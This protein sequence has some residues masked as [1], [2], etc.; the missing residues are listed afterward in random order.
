LRVRLP[1]NWKP[2]G[3]QRPAWDFLENGGKRAFMAWHRRAGK[4]EL[5]L[6]RTGVAAFERVGN[7][8]YMLPEAA[9]ARKAIWDAVNPHTGLR[10]LDEAFPLEIRDTT[11]DQEMM[12]RFANGSTF[13]VVGSDNYNSLVGSPPIGIVGSEWALAKPA[14][15]GFLRP[16]LLENGGWAI[17]N[18]TPRGPNHAKTMFDGAVGDPSW[19]TQKLTVDDTDVFTPEQLASER[20]EMIREYGP[21]FGES[22]FQQEYYC[23]WTAAVIGAYYGK[24]MAAAEEDGRITD[25]PYRKERP[26][27]TAWDIG[28]GNSDATGIWFFQLIGDWIHIIDYYEAVGEGVDHYAKV[29]RDK[30][31]AYSKHIGPHDVRNKEWGSG[32]ARIEV[33]RE[34]GV[35]FRIAPQVSII[36]GINAVRML[37]PRF[38]FDRTKCADGIDALRQYKQDYDED[39]S[40]FRDKPRHDWTSHAADGIRMMALGV[41]DEKGDVPSPLRNPTMDE[42]V[43]RHLQARAAMRS[44]DD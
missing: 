34:L 32:R 44:D 43:S 25:V 10:R 41:K 29:L 5:A 16:I 22:L 14:A 21:Q 11:R 37:F 12:I 15:W 38:R 13:Q 4:D 8:W 27:Q 30:G 36:D 18:T 9:Q 26:V 40:T 3:Y 39:R 1:N 19:F 42:M 24:E 6:H 2:R 33:A 7:Y 23:S 20:A 28:I 17:F 31:Y 35:T